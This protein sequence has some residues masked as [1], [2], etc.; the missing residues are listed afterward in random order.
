MSAVAC[1]TETWINGVPSSLTLLLPKFHLALTLAGFHSQSDFQKEPLFSTHIVFSVELPC[2]LSS[3]VSWNFCTHWAPGTPMTVWKQPGKR[4]MKPLSKDSKTSGLSSWIYFS[5]C[6]QSQHLPLRDTPHCHDIFKGASMSLH[7]PPSLSPKGS[8][9]PACTPLLFQVAQLSH[10]WFSFLSF[11][12][13]NW[14]PFPFNCGV[15]KPFP[16][17]LW[18]QYTISPLA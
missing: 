1:S 13:V 18:L 4:E 16:H 9:P 2:T 10:L 17:Q 11:T 6:R 5:P 12:E 7:T 8:K 15:S 3:K 14:A